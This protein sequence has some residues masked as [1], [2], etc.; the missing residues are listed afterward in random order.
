MSY[1]DEEE[2]AQVVEVTGEYARPENLNGHLLI[3]F[4]IGYHDYLP[5]RFTQ[6][7]KKSDALC[8]DVID[9]DDKD[10]AGVPGKVYRASNFM[11]SQLIVGLRPFIGRKVLGR[12]GKGVSKT[13]LNPP[14]VITDMSNDPVAI[15]RAK[16]WKVANPD[17]VTSPFMP[18]DDTAP[19][20]GAQPQPQPQLP[21]AWQQ[22]SRPQQ[23]TQQPMPQA[24]SQPAQQPAQQ[25]PLPPAAPVAGSVQATAEELNLLQRLR[26][27]RAREEAQRAQFQDE[28]PF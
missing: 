4:P 9:L 13:G 14:W 18:R 15:E 6:Q 11:Q 5:T 25:P 19:P 10:G 1:Q 28:P 2:F 22:Y 23:P 24:Y 8:C 20:A 27:E 21:E 26:M 16:A 17:F 3:V 7:G 12:M